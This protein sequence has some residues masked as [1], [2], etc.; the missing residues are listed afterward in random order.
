M[1]RA[2]RRWIS[3]KV[4]SLHESDALPFHDILDARMVDAAL[5]AEGVRFRERISTPLVA[6]CLFLCPGARSRSLLPRGGG[7]ADRLDSDRRPQAVRSGHR[8]L[9][10]GAASPAHGGGGPSGP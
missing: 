10:R 9:L 1:P 3:E 2:T 6:T 8:Q 5:A 7:R 4:K